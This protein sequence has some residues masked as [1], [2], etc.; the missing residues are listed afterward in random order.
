MTDA[1]HTAS[2]PIA[3]ARR[4]ALS[5]GFAAV[6]GLA[7]AA[8]AR[9]EA[10]GIKIT[11]LYGNPKNPEE[12]EK[13]YAGTH[14]PLV[15]DVKEIKR[16]ELALGIPGP[17][18]KPPPFYRITELYFDSAEQLKQAAETAQ[19][20]KVVEDVPKFASGGVTILLSKIA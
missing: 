16:S 8:V 11:A 19:W 2:S 12:F 18:G 14:M 15:Y 1:S 17:D 7:A 4:A 10:G 20:K 6:A 13:Y 9:A 5:L 3:V